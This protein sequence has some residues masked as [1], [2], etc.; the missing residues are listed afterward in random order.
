MLTLQSTPVTFSDI[1]ESDYFVLPQQGYCANCHRSQIYIYT[2][3]KILQQES[4]VCR[5]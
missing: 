1:N 4:V 5:D 2:C 3:Y